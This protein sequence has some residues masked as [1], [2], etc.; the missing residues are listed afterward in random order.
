MARKRK[1]KHR[2]PGISVFK[3]KAG[4]WYMK[5]TDPHTLKRHE[6]SLK[7]LGFDTLEQA[8]AYLLNASLELQDERRR[9]RIHGRR[10][11]LATTWP[12]AIEAYLEHYKE[13]NGEVSYARQEGALYAFR[14]WLRGDGRRFVTTGDVTRVALV[15]VHDHL[16]RLKKRQPRQGKRGANSMLNEPLSASSKNSYR[17]VIVALMN[18]LRRREYLRISSDDVRDA[19]PKF[20]EEKK[21]PVEVPVETLRAL[22]K[23]AVSNDLSMNFASRVDKRAYDVGERSDTAT[24]TYKPLFPLVALLVLTGM[25]LGEALHLRW[26][27][28][29]LSGKRICVRADRQTNWQVKT[30]H[31][32]NIGFTDSPAVERLLFGLTLR[33]GASAYVLP[34]TESSDPRNFNRKS[35]GRMLTSAGIPHVTPKMLRTTYAT[36]LASARKAPTPYQ[37]AF[38]MGHGVEVA[39]RHYVADTE[40]REGDRVEQWLQIDDVLTA[41]LDELRYPVVPKQEVGGRLA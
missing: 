4:S 28:V 11:L 37:L 3:N 2:Y 35:W 14:D 19:M 6:C 9:V 27:N 22:V 33:R 1:K 18:W 41:A 31:E 32:R 25:R 36:A 7:K 21:L 24:H 34:D 39:A 40:P 8:D 20:R 38:R 12:V 5:W 30:R 16:A 17:A 15:S 23:A 13:M 26:E 10:E 29:D